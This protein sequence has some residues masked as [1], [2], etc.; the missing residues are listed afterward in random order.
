MIF[1][2]GAN[3]FVLHGL[4]QLKINK[5]LGILGANG[6]GKSTALKILTKNLAINFGKYLD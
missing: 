3:Q 5:V 6:I 4:P 2:Y 1:W